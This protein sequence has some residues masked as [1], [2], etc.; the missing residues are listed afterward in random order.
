MSNE[1]QEVRADRGRSVRFKR[2]VL[3]RWRWLA[4]RGVELE[5]AAIEI[6]VASTELRAWLGEQWREAPL[7]VA[8]HVDEDDEAAAVGR[9]GLIV[10]LAGGVRVEGMTVADV[11]ELAR[12]LS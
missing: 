2:K 11:A 8:V 9:G 7:V 1:K 3:A 12:R 10:V 4:A 6:G 5:H